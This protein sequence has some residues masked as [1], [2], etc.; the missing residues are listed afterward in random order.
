MS[1][2][3]LFDAGSMTLLSSHRDI[4]FQTI[5][6]WLNWGTYQIDDGIAHDCVDLALLKQLYTGL[7]NRVGLATNTR[8]QGELR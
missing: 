2:H 6:S 3:H 7:G 5:F 4:D 1:L 8:E